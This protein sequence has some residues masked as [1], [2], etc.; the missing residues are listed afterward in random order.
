M[1]D[2]WG[3]EFLV[4][5]PKIR[6]QSAPEVTAL[7]T[8]GF[9]VAYSDTS[10][11][12]AQG[13]DDT[14]AF[15]V[16]LQIHTNFGGLAA[17]PFQV[18][19]ETVDDQRLPQITTLASGALM[20]VYEDASNG[21]QTGGDDLDAALRAQVFSATGARLG[22]GFLPTAPT[23]P[24]VRTQDEAA[25]A[26]LPGGG[27][28]MVYTDA[29]RS[30]GD[31]SEAVMLKVLTGAGA[32]Q[33]ADQRVNIRTKGAQSEA[34]VAA[35]A[36]GTL[37]VTWSD[38]SRGAK[39]IRLSLH[40]ASGARLLDPITVNTITKGEQFAPKVT[41]LAGGRFVVTWTDGSRTAGDGSDYAVRGRLFE[42]DGRPA[43]SDFL[44]NTAT[45]SLQAYPEI[46][47]LADGRFVIGWLDRS[48][49]LDTGFDDASGGAIRAQVFNADG[50][51]DG[52]EFLV[53]Q[54]TTGFQSDLSMAQL[55]DGRVI[56]TYL[57]TSMGV[58]TDFDDTT[59]AIRA[60]IFDP[61][62]GRVVWTGTDVSEEYAGT[63]GH[64]ILSGAGGD[65]VLLGSSG[66]DYLRG[67]AGDDSLHGQAGYDTL[68]GGSGN[69]RLAG[70][71]GHDRLRGG[72]GHD[73]LL[74]GGKNDR[75]FGE[76][77]RDRLAG[78]TGADLLSGGAGA[79]TFVFLGG[80]DSRPG[81]FTR[82][83][84]TDFEQ[85]RDRID[86]SALDANLLTGPNDAF[87]FIGGAAFS[88]QAGELR[89]VRGPAKTYVQADFD[90]DAR[91]DLAVQLHGLYTLSAGDF[92]L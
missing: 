21:V 69:D 26:A 18:N 88:G 7:A 27:V 19:V 55:Y 67:G 33:V 74:G 76:A 6:T 82:D 12:T 50:S 13:G 85:G 77:G 78:G 64:D 3:D 71:A 80:G 52:A 45:T 23:G 86:L 34:D 2:R 10:R 40:D 89:A 25:L 1:F 20:V 59:A 5:R 38:A 4:N 72:D 22:S 17:G 61:R 63:A 58:E 42:A 83:R 60:S 15:A 92:I 54:V 87:S 37:A 81:R 44:V 51:R 41:G 8:G 57:D 91:P 46:L 79:D 48:E 35:L 36:N 24:T 30:S 75:L 90:G 32:T 47:G 16:R 56:F 43:G 66:A 29:S 68:W 49:G 9:A 14:S 39:D 73:T 65:D 70:W 53:N 62:G 84:I 28:A 31:P 11:T